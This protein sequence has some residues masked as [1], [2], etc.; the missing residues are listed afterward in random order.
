MRPVLGL[1]PPA[2]ALVSVR[3]I[4]RDIEALPAAGVPVYAERGRNGGTA[5]LPGYRTDVTGQ[6]ADEARALFVLV[7]DQAHADL[8][9]GLGQ[10]IGSA[11]APDCFRSRGR[12]KWRTVQP[13]ARSAIMLAAAS[14]RRTGYYRTAGCD[15]GAQDQRFAIG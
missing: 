3:T 9:L 14:T 8:G 4:F 12:R 6:T 10:A 5:L 1:A 2:V 11:L 13:A 15:R 7:T